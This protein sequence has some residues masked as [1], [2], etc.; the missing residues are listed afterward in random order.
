[1]RSVEKMKKEIDEFEKFIESRREGIHF[2]EE[3]MKRYPNIPTDVISRTI[4]HIR[5]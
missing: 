5:G 2:L 1:M 3:F 4:F